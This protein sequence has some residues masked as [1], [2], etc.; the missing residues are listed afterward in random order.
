MPARSTIVLALTA[1]GALGSS[2]FVLPAPRAR[3]ASTTM[4][5]EQSSRRQVL[6]TGA[7][8]ILA[9]LTLAPLVSNAED[10]P[11]VRDKMGG[12]LEPYSD[13]AK[14]MNSNASSDR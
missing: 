10:V 14:V 8:A 4:M 11:L 6:S 12:L 1:A 2:A 5:A 3:M 13:I 9:G 7:A